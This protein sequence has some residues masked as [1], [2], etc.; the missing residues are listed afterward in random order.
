MKDSK[1]ATVYFDPAVHRALSRKAAQS[2]QSI[3]DVVNEAVDPRPVAVEKL[4][5]EQNLYRIRQGNYRIVY[6]VDDRK[7]VIVITKIGDRKDVYR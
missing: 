3:S 4:S 6:S 7:K 1:R 2:D 5:A